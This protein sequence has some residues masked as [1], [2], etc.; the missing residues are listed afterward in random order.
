M[1]SLFIGQEAKAMRYM[2]QALVDAVAAT[3]FLHVAWHVI[4]TYP[5]YQYQ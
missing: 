3:D 5:T 4:F 2:F 1:K